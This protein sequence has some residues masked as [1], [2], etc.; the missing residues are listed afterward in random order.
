MLAEKSKR[1]SSS[2]AKRCLEI[3][4]GYNV[5]EPPYNHAELIYLQSG[6]VSISFIGKAKSLHVVEKD[7]F[8]I[9]PRNRGM[10][11]SAIKDSRLEI[12]RL[13]YS[14]PRIL[15]QSLTEI[16]TGIFK[17]DYSSM[18]M[19]SLF[20]D[21]IK[22]SSSQEFQSNSIIQ[23]CIKNINSRKGNITIKELHETLGISKSTLEQHFIKA[24]GLSPKEYCRIEKL[25]HFLKSYETLPKYSLTELAY[26][27]GYYDQSHLIKDFQYFLNTSPKRYLTSN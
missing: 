16:S 7:A 5:A 3:V 2:V 27:C 1:Q 25:N 13:P 12:V 10:I 20:K 22:I 15:S 23:N 19:D 4:S 21:L 17:I 26:Y 9:S 18:G 6:E 8:I 11:I 24:L 14:S